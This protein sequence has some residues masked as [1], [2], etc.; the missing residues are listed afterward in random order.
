MSGLV[1][2]VDADRETFKVSVSQN[3]SGVP[4]TTPLK[5]RVF[6]ELDEDSEQTMI[7]LPLLHT[8]VL[9]TGDV[10]NVE[11]RIVYLSTNDVTSLTDFKYNVDGGN[12]L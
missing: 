3:I 11:H 5:V 4:G 7:E 9:L 2:A 12:V 1:T 10:M 6:F 8:L